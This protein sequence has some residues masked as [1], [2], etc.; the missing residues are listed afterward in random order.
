MKNETL[1]SFFKEYK[2]YLIE[3]D[4]SLNTADQ[5]CTYLR[6][7]CAFLNLGEGFIEAIIAIA[8]ANVQAALCEYL[9]AK[10]SNEFENAQDKIF[11]KQILQKK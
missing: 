5:Y 3:T 2:Q 10:L 11:K 4:H 8:D 1:K 9:M 6:K 7:A